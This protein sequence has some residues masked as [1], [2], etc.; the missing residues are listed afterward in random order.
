MLVVAAGKK[1]H[2]PQTSQSPAVKL[3]NGVRI[4]LAGVAVVSEVPGVAIVAVSNSP[5][6]PALALLF[7]V[8]PTIPPVWLGVIEPVIML[9]V[10]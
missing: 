9:N 8:V 6:E 3:R 2:V 7:V 4:T 10:D 1:Q 5:T